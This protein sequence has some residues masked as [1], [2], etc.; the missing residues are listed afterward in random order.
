MISKA[1]D[2]RQRGATEIKA[3]E[4][5]NLALVLESQKRSKRNNKYTNNSKEERFK[6]SRCT[7]K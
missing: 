1:L 3:K 4:Q 7:S 6:P 2:T 5:C